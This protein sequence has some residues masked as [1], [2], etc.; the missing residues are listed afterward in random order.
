MARSAMA[1]RTAINPRPY[2]NTLQCLVMHYFPFGLIY[3]PRRTPLRVY[4]I[5]L[6]VLR[7][8]ELR[9]SNTILLTI[10]SPVNITISRSCSMRV[11][12]VPSLSST[13]T[14][15]MPVPVLWLGTNVNPVSLG[16]L[17]DDP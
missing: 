11:G 3:I 6:M 9:R 12:R 15:R 5:R 4:S 16:Y 7:R 1:Y 8:R 14:L 17:H 13:T 2:R 10:I